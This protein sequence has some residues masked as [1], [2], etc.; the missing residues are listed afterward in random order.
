MSDLAIAEHERAIER[1][2]SLHPSLC[3]VENEQ[4]QVVTDRLF[5]H[6]TDSD[7]ADIEASL[8]E[9]P[10]DIRRQFLSESPSAFRSGAVTLASKYSK[11]DFLRR[12]NLS[13][14]VPPPDIHSMARPR[15]WMGDQYHANMIA[16]ILT[17][18]GIGLPEHGTY[19][20]FGCSSGR[21]VRTLC[22]AFQKAQWHGC[23]PQETAIAWARDNLQ[24][25]ICFKVSPLSPPTS[26]SD[27][28]FDGAFAISIW[29]HYGE[30]AAKR[31]LAEMARIIRRGGWLLITTCGLQTLIHSLEN[32]RRNP[33]L[34]IS[35]AETA[36]R[37]GFAFHDSF[38]KKGDWGI[39]NVDWGFAVILPTWLL[40]EANACG[41]DLA[42]Y[43]PGRLLKNQ[44][45]YLL[46]RRHRR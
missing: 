26:Y 32:K 46:Y 21:I 27:G 13:T 2:R 33:A 19:L 1:I 22:A 12:A 28:Q 7:L 15:I 41:F 34:C 10:E 20:D 40:R 45:V 6:V 18:D 35:M 3:I 11:G 23:D 36:A 4:T 25:E 5:A 16:E 9:A 30:S 31:W 17:Q 43:H 37:N 14:A 44:D 42:G 39:P 38:G 8:H 24:K 29:S